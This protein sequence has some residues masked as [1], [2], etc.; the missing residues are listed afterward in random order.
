[1]ELELDQLEFELSRK[2]KKISELYKQLDYDVTTEASESD[3]ESSQISFET[4]SSADQSEQNQDLFSST[5]IHA[6]NWKSNQEL[7]QKQSVDNVKSDFGARPPIQ[8]LSHYKSVNQSLVGLEDQNPLLKDSAPDLSEQQPWGL[9]LTSKLDEQTCSD[10]CEGPDAL[11][12]GNEEM[13]SEVLLLDGTGDSSVVLRNYLTQFDSKHSRINSWLLHKLRTSSAEIIRLRKAVTDYTSS[14]E[15]WEARSLNAWEHDY[16]T[17][18]PASSSATTDSLDPAGHI[19]QPQLIEPVALPPTAFRQER[20]K[21]TLI[22]NDRRVS[23]TSS[24]PAAINEDGCELYHNHGIY[25]CEIHD[26]EHWSINH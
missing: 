16:P 26:I 21:L 22:G 9:A 20:R 17:F 1:M 10:P 18:S 12:E 14:I 25:Q 6:S 2:G 7:T 11:S 8:F 23:V 5:D 15:N 19:H 13:V 4:Q 3:I 24:A